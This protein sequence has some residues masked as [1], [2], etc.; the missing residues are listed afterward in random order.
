[1]W[2]FST[3]RTRTRAVIEIPVFGHS[4]ALTARDVGV[5]VGNGRNFWLTFFGVAPSH[6]NRSQPDVQHSLSWGSSLPSLYSTY[7]TFPPARPPFPTPRIFLLPTHQQH[8]PSSSK[9][10]RTADIMHHKN[11]RGPSLLS[12]LSFSLSLWRRHACIYTMTTTTI[13]YPIIK[14]R[15]FMQRRLV[16]STAI[17]ILLTLLS[18]SCDHHYLEAFSTTTTHRRRGTEETLPSLQMTSQHGE[19]NSAAT[20]LF[21][22]SR[23]D[24]LL[25]SSGSTAATAAA[26][27]ASFAIMLAAVTAPSPARAATDTTAS[28]SLN[29]FLSQLVQAEQQLRGVPQWI[30]TEKWD[31]VRAVLITP[32]LSDCWAKT[33]RPLLQKYAEALGRAGGDELAAL[34]AKEELQGHLRY[35]DM[36]VYNNNFNPIIVEGTT[37]ASPTLIQSYYQDPQ[38]EYQASLTSLQELIRLAKETGV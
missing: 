32:P 3:T 1:V 25:A 21:F 30:D 23:R 35:L 19:E 4:R 24:I 27:T 17:I 9:Q 10:V 7:V 18:S 16:S 13:L 20:P 36:A 8:Q 37:N 26:A 2:I 33:N 11:N 15:T 22:S 14:K 6:N 38:R 31:S 34:Q 5:I 29:D 12:L 28:S